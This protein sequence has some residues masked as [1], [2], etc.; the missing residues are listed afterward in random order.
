MSFSAIN[1]QRII[2]KTLFCILM[3]AFLM[4]NPAFADRTLTA[5]EVQVILYSLTQQPVGTW[6]TAGSITARHL[7]YSG[8]EKS[9][10]EYRET[11]HYDGLRFYR[12]INMMPGENNT[13]SNVQTEKQNASTMDRERI[14]CWDGFTYTQY[15]KSA[16]AAVIQ[17]GQSQA[18]FGTFGPFSAG[19]IPWGRGIYTL[20]KLSGYACTAR[21]VWIE[22]RRQIHLQVT[23]ESSSPLLQM[24]F[25]LDPD[26]NYAATSHRIEDPQLSGIDR[27]YSQFVQI[28]DRWIPTVIT[29]ERFLKKPQGNQVVSYEDW[30]FDEIKPDVPQDAQF[31]VKLKND[32]LVELHSSG[33]LKSLMYYVNDQKDIASLLDEKTEFST[34]QDSLGKNCAVAAIQLVTRQFSRPYPV[35]QIGDIV[36]QNNKMTSLYLLKGKLEETGLYCA[37]VETSLESLREI[38]GCQIILHLEDNS[39]YVI[40]DRIDDANVWT[41]DLTSRKVYWKTPIS[42]FLQQWTR[43]VALIVSDIPQT[44]NIG[45]TPISASD[46]QQIFGGDSTGTTY[47]CSDLIQQKSYLLCPKATGLVCNGRYYT[48]WDR[49]G[50]IADPN[51][52]VCTGDG[53]PGHAYTACDTIIDDSISC[54]RDE[55]DWHYRDIRACK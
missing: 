55:Y 21:E 37:A 53:M 38:T 41:I 17:S 31:K 15:Y 6:L 19:L 27:H 12:E 29:I 43:G 18:P 3:C 2:M 39:H 47:S 40:M 33:D 14:F 16:A 34:Q 42:Q 8:T 9:I 28:N 7:E 50:C 52:G 4:S 23:D 11:A 1:I 44:S 24:S 54:A 22:G 49:Y 20:Q 36:A 13:E 51:G 30:T 46:Q 10:C 35:N 45:G 48:Y 5:D 32:T 26:K 25:V